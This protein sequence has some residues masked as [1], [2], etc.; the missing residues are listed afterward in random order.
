[1]Y[2]LFE[3]KINMKYK[4]FSQFSVKKLVMSLT[5]FAIFALSTAEIQS[6]FSLQR[7]IRKFHKTIK[8]F[9][10][11]RFFHK[12]TLETKKRS[13]IPFNKKQNLYPLFSRS[14]DLGYALSSLI[15][16]EKKSIY[17]SV[18]AITDPIVINALCNA[19][20]RGV[21]I[22]VVLDKQ[23]LHY[24]NI[25][26][27]KQDNIPVFVYQSKTGG[28]MHN[29]IALF[30]RNVINGKEDCVLWQG[31]ANFSIAAKNKNQES[32]VVIRN[33][34]RLFKAFSNEFEIIK[35]ESTI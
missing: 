28:L 16:N 19:K 23:S 32:V 27:L 5:L 6:F 13:S 33:N 34:K 29:K 30:S 9:N 1:M 20:N 35:Q 10:F 15:D 24:K 12:S 22:E 8:R 18:F 31:S 26:K 21:H 25:E 11:V 3:L 2:D 17:I 4:Y 14:T 7:I